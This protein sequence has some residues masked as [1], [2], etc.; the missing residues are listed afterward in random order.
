MQ[1]EL[2]FLIDLLRLDSPAYE[3]LNLWNKPDEDERIDHIKA[4][5]ESSQN[6]TQF[7]SIGQEHARIH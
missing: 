7:G 2:I 4:G 6:E 3:S 5:M 1:A